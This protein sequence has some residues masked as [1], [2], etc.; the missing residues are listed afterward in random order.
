MVIAL[1]TSQ[2]E[3]S[4]LKDLASLNMELMLTTLDTSHVEMSSS[5]VTVLARECGPS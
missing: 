1:D 3:M 5:S 2:F 4:A